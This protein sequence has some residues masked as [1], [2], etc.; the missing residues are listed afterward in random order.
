MSRTLSFPVISPDS[1]ID[2]RNQG[3]DLIADTIVAAYR[4]R[5]RIAIAEVRYWRHLYAQCNTD[6]EL[7]LVQDGLRHAELSLRDLWLYYRGAR[8]FRGRYCA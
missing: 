4:A 8:A 6:A 7:A 1:A 3:A 2:T 5:L